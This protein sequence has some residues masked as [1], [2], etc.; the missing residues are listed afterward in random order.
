MVDPKDLSDEEL[1]AEL[2]R[3]EQARKAQA[4]AERLERERREREAKEAMF[5]VIRERSDA[6]LAIT[7]HTRTS[8]SDENPNNSRR[9][10]TRC[11]LLEFLKESWAS[12]EDWDIE[13][14]LKRMY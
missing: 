14:D 1:Y 9:G 5:A 11:V 8:C 4:E 13:F 12:T 3:R 6:F 10:C 7:P 2:N